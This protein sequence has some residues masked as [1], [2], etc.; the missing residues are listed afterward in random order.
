MT[1]VTLI[2]C[3]ASKRDEKAPAKEMY[4][5]SV[6][7]RA[8][9]NWA[10]ARGHPW[11]IISAKHGL[12]SPE[13]TIKPYDERGIDEQQAE[14]IGHDIADRGTQTIHI[15]AGQDYT[16]ELIP[17]L[18][19][20]GIDVIVHCAGDRI[21]TRCQKLNEKTQKLANQDLC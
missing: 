3:T 17:V 1:E 15:C 19:S 10:E 5:E 21:G 20:H 6:Y 12:L 16:T 14:Q 4:D 18:E 2:Q 7:F 9:R 13:T 11:Y 8:M